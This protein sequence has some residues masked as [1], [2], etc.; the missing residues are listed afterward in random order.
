MI[1]SRRACQRL[2]TE[3]L[4]LNTSEDVL[5]GSGHTIFCLQQACHDLR[6]QH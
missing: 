2:V 6:P 3:P 5:S 1:S 4:S